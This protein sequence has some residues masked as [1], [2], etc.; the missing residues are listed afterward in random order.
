[1]DSQ[2]KPEEPELETL[3]QKRNNVIEK[4]NNFVELGTYVN[5]KKID[6]NELNDRDFDILIYAIEHSNSVHLVKYILNQTHYETLNYAF[7]DTGKYKSFLVSVINHQIDFKGFKIPLFTAIA[8]NKFKMADLLIKRNADINYQINGRDYHNVDIINYLYYMS[9]FRDFLNRRNLKYILINGFH[10]KTINTEVVNKMINRN[11]N[12]GLLDILLKNYIYDNNFIIHLL[13]MYHYKVAASDKD[14][15]KMIN[16]EKNKIMIDE[17]VYDNADE[18]ENYDAIQMILDYDSSGKE[19]INDRIEDY[20]LLEKGV[21]YDNYALVQKILTHPF[22]DMERLHLDKALA[23]AS[24]NIRLDIL[25]LLLNHI[26]QY[27]SIDWKTINY[28][29]ILGETS[30][31]HNIHYLEERKLK[32]IKVMQMFIEPLLNYSFEQQDP[33]AMGNFSSI[34]I[35]FLKTLNSSYIILIINIIIKIGHLDLLKYILENEELKSYIDVDGQDRNGECPLITAYLSDSMEIFQYLLNY[36]A[37]SHIKTKEGKYLLYL[38]IQHKNYMAIKYLLKRNLLLEEESTEANT[39]TQLI[40]QNKVKIIETVFEIDENQNITKEEDDDENQYTI[41]EIEMEENGIIKKYNLNKLLSEKNDLLNFPNYGF[42]YLILAYLLNYQ[43]I[44]EILLQHVDIN[45]LD[46]NGFNI[47]HYVL[48]KEDIPTFIL[49]LNLGAEVNYYE[50]VVN[51]RRGN[52]ALDIVIAI[53]NMEIFNILLNYPSTKL[54]HPNWR[55]ETPLSTTIKLNHYPLNLKLKLI[56]QLVERG[57]DVNYVD[58]SRNTPLIYAIQEKLNPIAKFL[59]EKGAE[60]NFINAYGFTPLVFAVN[61]RYLPMVKILVKYGADINFQIESK[62]ESKSQSLFMLAV[63]QGE[64]NVVK[65]LI[66]CGIDLHFSQ[67]TVFYEFMEAINKNGKKEIFE[68]IAEK[69]MDCFTSAMVNEIVAWNRID[70]MKILIKHHLDVNIRDEKGN[71]PLSYAIRFNERLMVHYLIEQGSNIYNVNAN[72][73]TIYELSQ[74]CYDSNNNSSISIHNKIK[75]RIEER[76]N[77]I[78]Y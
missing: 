64:V 34:N 12:E 45:E 2:N 58:S 65:Y 61:K 33:H 26:R 69:R 41:R 75:R 37:N 4:I 57:G 24:K 5:K 56:E 50:D 28:E 62:N 17:S 70:L 11:Y 59:I 43:E 1:M 72:G 14:L 39:L 16:D 76:K 44:F 3:E 55:S 31:Y 49:L 10:I 74:E 6:L 71:I 25:E 78:N 22:V 32:H 66:D 77:G 68:Y 27:P 48:L 35:S 9:G 23:E 36:G 54:N 47:L 52:S 19:V 8:L 29:A 21:E 67:M 42:T 51:K 15:Q 53:Q 13:S 7:Y 18:R 63:T 20:E 73:Q 30:H 38:A 60:V 40:L 46:S